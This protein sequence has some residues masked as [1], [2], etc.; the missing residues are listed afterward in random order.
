MR[1]FNNKIYTN[2]AISFLSLYGKATLHNIS[3]IML[4]SSE[5][6]NRFSLLNTK[7]P[8]THLTEAFL[9]P[10]PRTRNSLFILQRVHQPTYFN[11]L[12]NSELETRY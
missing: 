12:H 4:P 5:V 8:H 9:A 7:G 3:W 2:N 6:T 11:Y 10:Q 1:M